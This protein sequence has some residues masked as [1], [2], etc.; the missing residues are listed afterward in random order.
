MTSVARVTAAHARYANHQTDAD[1]LWLPAENG[2]TGALHLKLGWHR[3][4]TP[5]VAVAL[6]DR[7]GVNVLRF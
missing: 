6:R 2:A 4:L 3:A 5:P 7:L 1:P